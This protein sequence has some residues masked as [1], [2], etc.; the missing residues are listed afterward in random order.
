MREIKFRAWW[1]DTNKPVA[2]FNTEYIIDACNSNGFIVEQFTGLRDKTKD[3]TEI[4]ESDIIDAN[5][6]VKGNAHENGNLLKDKTNLLIQGFG[7]KDWEAT[8]KAA[9]DRGCE[10]SE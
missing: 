4:Y 10:Y 1:K 9:M 8:N 7:T 3:L 5:G 6:A 2:D